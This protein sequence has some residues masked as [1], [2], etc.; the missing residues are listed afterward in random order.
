MRQFDD[1]DLYRLDDLLDDEDRMVRD[2]VREWVQERVMPDIESWAWNEVFPAELVPE[3]GRLDML[4]PAYSE[5]DLPGLGATAC[6][7]IAAIGVDRVQLKPADCVRR[8][9]AP[10]RRQ[11]FAVILSALVAASAERTW[12]RNAKAVVAKRTRPAIFRPTTCW[13]ASKWFPTRSAALSIPK[14][15]PSMI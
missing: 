12:R 14:S 7:A 4:G 8:A 13:R 2:A 9:N 10:F 1:L 6:R 11:R 3:M 15:R 5:Y